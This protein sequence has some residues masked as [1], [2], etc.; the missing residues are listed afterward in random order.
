[1]RFDHLSHWRSCGCKPLCSQLELVEGM[2]LLT[3]LV[4]LEVRLEPGAETKGAWMALSSLTPWCWMPPSLPIFV[5]S[6][7]DLSPCHGFHSHPSA[8][9]PSAGERIL[10]LLASTEGKKKTSNLMSCDGLGS[11][12]NGAPYHAMGTSVVSS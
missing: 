3:S 8:M 4:N 12:S 2:W 1:M 10:L 7:L 11:L 5:F 6:H 9:H